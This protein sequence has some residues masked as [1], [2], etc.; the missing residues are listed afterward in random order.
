MDAERTPPGFPS[1]TA[2]EEAVEPGD[3]GERTLSR[4]M[5]I[6][7]AMSPLVPQTFRVVES[8]ESGRQTG[9]VSDGTLGV[10][11]VVAGAPEVSS[12]EPSPIKVPATVPSPTSIVSAPAGATPLRQI[13]EEQAQERETASVVPREPL[14]YAESLGPYDFAVPPPVVLGKERDADEAAS[15]SCLPSTSRRGLSPMKSV[16]TTSRVVGRGRGIRIKATSAFVTPAPAEPP[17]TVSSLGKEVS[18]LSVRTPPTPQEMDGRESDDDLLDFYRN[19]N[20]ALAT[21]RGKSALHEAMLKLPDNTSLNYPRYRQARVP[22]D[23]NQNRHASYAVQ[24]NRDLLLNPQS[25]LESYPNEKNEQDPHNRFTEP[26]YDADFRCYGYLSP[27]DQPR[28]RVLILTDSS[29]DYRLTPSFLIKDVTTL[30]LPRS[31][32][33]QMAGFLESFV[34]AGKANSDSTG[35]P[36]P[37]LVVLMNL[38]DHLSAEDQL[39]QLLKADCPTATIQLVASEFAQ[40]L[41]G[42]HKQAYL[43]G[44]QLV[45]TTPPGF[46]GWPYPVQLMVLT[47]QKA[48]QTFGLKF[49]ITAPNMPVDLNFRPEPINWPGTFAW[50]SKTIQSMPNLEGYDLTL[51]DVTFWDWS[52]AMQDI[53]S[54]SSCADDC[55]L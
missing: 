25:G 30:S 50:L 13:M 19:R 9:S 6:E 24:F 53:V 3:E 23:P 15:A 40:T 12:H 39:A 27:E 38:F 28:T 20:F 45:T 5:E 41:I 14:T 43:K 46:V 10:L 16:P 1:P 22:K 4:P 26:W 7:E 35:G 2:R 34:E 32:L 37:E 44:Y 29:I 55:V 49:S 33:A 21:S 36:Y 18:S 42:L 51:D 17:V 47:V 52:N 11:P 31:N 8:A 48:L 54:E